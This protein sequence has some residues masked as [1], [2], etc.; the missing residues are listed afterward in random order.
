MKDKISTLYSIVVP[1]YNSTRSLLVLAE[2][3]DSLFTQHVVDGH[4][5][6][7]FVDDASPNPK[8]WETLKRLSEKE[9]SVVAIRLMRNFGQQAATLC[10]MKAAKGNFVI[11]IDDDLQQNPDDIAKLVAMSSH[12]IVI[13]QFKERKHAVS[14]V[15]TSKMKGWFDSIILGKPW[16]LKLTSFRLLKKEVVEG[17]LTITTPHPFIPALMFYTTK[18]IVGVE[19]E[20]RPRSEGDSGYSFIALTRLF[21]NLLIN[22]SS[23]LLRFVGLVG[24]LTSFFSII[25]SG[26]FVGKKLLWGIPVTGWTSTIVLILFFGGAILFS[27]GIIGEYL[28]RIIRG[29]ERKPSYIIRET[30]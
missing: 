25:S 20:H 11:T 30:V 13:A 9:H 27:I 22:N 24:G 23:L 21:S 8:T 29:V 7:I 26:Y 14:K 10:G 5:E 2:R 17:M 12:D 16:G 19:M 6:I 28:I 1:V 18:D 15:I 3:V 4:Y